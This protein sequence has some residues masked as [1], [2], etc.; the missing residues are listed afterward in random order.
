MSVK[1]DFTVTPDC[2]YSDKKCKQIVKWY[3]D[4]VSKDEYSICPV[5]KYITGST[6]RYHLSFKIKIGR[7]DTR[8]NALSIA[9][10]IVSGDN[11]ISGHLIENTLVYKPTKETKKREAT[12]KKETKKKETIKETKKREA[13][14]YTKKKRCPNGSRKNENGECIPHKTNNKTSNKVSNKVSANPTRRERLLQQTRRRKQ[15]I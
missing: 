6:N 11:T 1:V 7:E 9:R 15:N 2:K 13:T 10:S 12:K 8:E 3:K 14:I 5:I 4:R